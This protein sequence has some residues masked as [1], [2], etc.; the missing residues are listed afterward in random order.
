MQQTNPPPKNSA[1][2]VIM[3]IC[4]VA[5]ALWKALPL[6]QDDDY[7][8]GA[9][10][11]LS[12]FALSLAGLPGTKFPARR[13]LFFLSSALAVGVLLF[14]SVNPYKRE[15]KNIYNMIFFVLAICIITYYGLIH[16]KDSLESSGIQ[17]RTE[18]DNRLPAAESSGINQ[19]SQSVGE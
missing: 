2:G 12:G 10:Y 1:A 17:N 9:A 15:V 16:E 14:L 4:G 19:P 3:F 13:F 7:D 6:V 18:Q 8:A 11:V 5:L